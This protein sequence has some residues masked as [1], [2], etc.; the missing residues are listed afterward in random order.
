MR[1][2]Q[3]PL[4][5]CKGMQRIGMQTNDPLDVGRGDQRKVADGMKLLCATDAAA[6]W[7]V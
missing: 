1:V 6:E 4:L 5:A 3:L 7:R 2:K